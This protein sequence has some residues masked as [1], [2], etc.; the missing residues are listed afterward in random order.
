M[1]WGRTFEAESTASIKK[2]K[3]GAKYGRNEKQTSVAKE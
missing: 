1:T 3:K 2:P